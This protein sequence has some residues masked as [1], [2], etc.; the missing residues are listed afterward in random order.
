MTES[1]VPRLPADDLRIAKQFD[2][3]KLGFEV[4]FEAT[5]DAKDGILGLRRGT[6][7][8]WRAYYDAWRER[9][10]IE[11]P[12]RNESWGGRTFDLVDPFGNTIF[13]IGPM[14]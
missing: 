2:V 1:A 6:R 8:R 4:L 11:R 7:C 14:T 3:E 10:T 5:A 13:V 12:P 9:V